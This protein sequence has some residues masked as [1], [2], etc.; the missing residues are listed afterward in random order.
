MTPV[1][2][3]FHELTRSDD[4]ALDEVDQWI[5]DNN[6]FAEKGG[7]MPASELNAKI[8]ARF[9]PI[10]KHY[11]EFLAKH[12]NYV[13]GYLAYG[14]FLEDAKD[15]DAAIVQYDK[16][17]ILDPSNPVP[18]SQ[19]ANY[20]AH[21]SPVKKAFEYLA[22][23][24]ELK[25]DE[26]LYYR[27]LGTIVYLFRTDAK[28]YYHLNEQQVFDKALALYDEAMK[29]DPQNFELAQ[30]VAQT[31]YGIKPTRTNAALMAW[32]N[33]FKLADTELEKEA[34][35]IHYA[36]F[37]LISDRFAEA[38]Q[39]LN[40]VTNAIYADL[41]NRVLR[42]VNQREQKEKN[43]DSVLP[44]VAP[45]AQNNSKPVGEIERAK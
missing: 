1:E 2:A 45:D 39:T 23:A 26:S 10:R 40:L 14:S 9:A 33:A 28:E 38:R 22:K 42:N 43:P 34:V 30:D 37:F 8:L 5:R 19:L 36:R 25:P 32:T 24:I 31:Y 18:W 3:E 6:A 7:G 12:T 13:K 11:D 35:Y 29:Y 41:K 17:R 21:Y 27:N 16:A 4:A 44:P 15:E 20:Y